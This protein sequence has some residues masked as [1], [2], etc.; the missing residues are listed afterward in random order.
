MLPVKILFNL[1][2]KYLQQKPLNNV[3]SSK[4]RGQ[5]NCT[6]KYADYLVLLAKEGMVLQDM[7]MNDFKLVDIMELK[8]TWKKI[9]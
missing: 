7:I 3:V 1:Q 6:V 5:V 2:S 4:I 8:R 9:K